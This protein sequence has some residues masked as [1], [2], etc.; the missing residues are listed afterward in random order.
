MGKRSE[1]T[2]HQRYKRQKSLYKGTPHYMSLRKQKLTI[3]YHHTIHPSENPK[4]K[5]L[6]PPNAGKDM[7]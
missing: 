3:R 7:E 5:A 1:Q 4:S 2:P 6:K